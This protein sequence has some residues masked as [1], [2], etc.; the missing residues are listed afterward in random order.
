[1]A[2]AEAAAQ[3]VL[4]MRRLH[5]VV[6]RY[7]R[8]KLALVWCKHHRH[9]LAFQFVGVFLQGTRV[10]VEIFALAKLQAVDK[11]THHHR[12]GMLVRRAHQRQM[13]LV[14]I[15]HGGHKSHFA[16]VFTPL[17]QLGNGMNDLHNKYG[18]IQIDWIA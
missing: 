15:A 18:P 12:I 16:G 14:Q 2:G 11:N 17:P 13:P 8:I 10:A 3:L 7:V 1:M 9:A 6:L 4:Q 5:I